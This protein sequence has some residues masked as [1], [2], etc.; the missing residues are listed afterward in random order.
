MLNSL[1]K[2]IYMCLTYSTGGLKPPKAS[3]L[4]IRHWC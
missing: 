2:R 4:W 3:P 1:E